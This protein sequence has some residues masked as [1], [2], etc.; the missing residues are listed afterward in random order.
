MAFTSEECWIVLILSLAAVCFFASGMARG[1][2]EHLIH[3]PFLWN[4]PGNGLEHEDWIGRRFVPI[5]SSQFWNYSVSYLNKYKRRDRKSG[6]AFPLSTSILVMFTDG[7]HLA[8]FLQSISLVLGVSI[9]IAVSPMVECYYQSHV[10]FVEYWEGSLLLSVA[11]LAVSNV[12]F[13]TIYTYLDYGS[14]TQMIKD[15]FKKIIQKIQM[16]HDSP[17]KAWM[18]Y[19]SIFLLAFLFIVGGTVLIENLTGSQQ[20]AGAYGAT[21]ILGFIGWVVYKIIKGWS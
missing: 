4:D 16:L 21:L 12:G 18:A 10:F 6:P 2:R 5:T 9:L 8:R 15:M 13:Q 19:A 14:F 7:Y 11:M 20:I 17:A 1:L 3:K